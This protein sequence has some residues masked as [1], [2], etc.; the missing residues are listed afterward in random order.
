MYL[1]NSVMPYASTAT[2]LMQQKL[3]DLR[4]KNL[5]YANQTLQSIMSMKLILT[6]LCPQMFEEETLVSMFDASH[7]SDDSI[8]GQTGSITGIRMQKV[9]GNEKIFHPVAL[10]SRNQRRV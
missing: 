2:S 7:G 9:N 1:G 6:Y 3:D 5:I 10:T 8:Y 4:F